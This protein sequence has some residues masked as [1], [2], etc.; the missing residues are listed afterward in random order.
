MIKINGR[1][2]HTAGRGEEVFHGLQQAKTQRD[3]KL[4]VT[5]FQSA[6]ATAAVAAG[7]LRGGLT[8]HFQESSPE[9]EPLIN[10]IVQIIVLLMK[11][12]RCFLMKHTA[13]VQVQRNA[14]VVQHV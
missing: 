6:T 13:A 10:M 5:P 12:Q 2:S 3:R 1:N 7:G 11:R 4:E 9:Y 8:F 14:A